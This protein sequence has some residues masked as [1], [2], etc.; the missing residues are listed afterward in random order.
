[1][2]ADDFSGM[3]ANNFEEIDE[4]LID[5]DAAML[6]EYVKT[7]ILCNIEAYACESVL[8]R[9]ECLGKKYGYPDDTRALDVLSVAAR[10]GR[11]DEFAERLEIEYEKSFSYVSPNAK[12]R[13]PQNITIE[14]AKFLDD[15][16]FELKFS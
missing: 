9:A 15:C 10:H 8:A 5:I 3:P 11:F 2:P 4:L 13:T 7:A 1:M 6:K 12:T 14:K 16:M